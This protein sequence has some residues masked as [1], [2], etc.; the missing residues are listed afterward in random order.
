[1]LLAELSAVGF[2][3]A[4]LHQRELEPRLGVPCDTLRLVSR[5]TEV[6][7]NICLR[8][9]CKGALGKHGLLSP[10][11]HHGIDGRGHPVGGG[12]KSA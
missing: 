1:M 6:L 9:L 7:H 12:G 4:N 8:S 5:Y 3:P 11:L 2:I 10:L